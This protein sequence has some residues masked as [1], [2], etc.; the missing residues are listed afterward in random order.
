MSPTAG[1]LQE[2]RFRGGSIVF[3]TGSNAT[4]AAVNARGNRGRFA[5]RAMGF[6]REFETANVDA[7]ANF[8]EIQGPLQGVDS[9][10]TRVAA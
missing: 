10:L 7:L 5:S 6:L 2:I 8:D 9:L 3:V 1:P 4:L